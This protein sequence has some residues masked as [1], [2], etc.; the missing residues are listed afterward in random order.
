M[1]AQPVFAELLPC[2][3]YMHHERVVV[4]GEHKLYV[5]YTEN[6]TELYHLPDDPT[7]QRNLASARPEVVRAL[8]ALLAQRHD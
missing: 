2:T 3:A 6:T 8:K 4:D 7:E 1:P 5:K